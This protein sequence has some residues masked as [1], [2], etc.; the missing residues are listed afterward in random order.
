MTE[1]VYLDEIK[2]ALPLSSFTSGESSVLRADNLTA[3]WS[4]DCDNLTLEDVSFTVDKVCDYSI[5]IIHFILSY[6]PL[7]SRIHCWLL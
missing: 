2:E 4:M 6:L 7:F 3:S 5:S 1:T